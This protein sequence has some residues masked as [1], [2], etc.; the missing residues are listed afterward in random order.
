M[1]ETI[2][3]KEK[4]PA[5]V[6]YIPAGSLV[7]VFEQRSLEEISDFYILYVLFLSPTLIISI[8]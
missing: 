1:V 8:N 6:G 3:H 4:S 5:D 7:R 2:L